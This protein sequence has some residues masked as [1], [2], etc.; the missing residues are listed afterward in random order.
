MHNPKT[1]QLQMQISNVCDDG[2][3]NLKLEKKRARIIVLR[4][5]KSKLACNEQE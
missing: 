2:F 5:Q 3:N 1:W 4:N